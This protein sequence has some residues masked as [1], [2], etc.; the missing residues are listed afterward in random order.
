MELQQG[1]AD[2]IPVGG[3]FRIMCLVQDR[4][5]WMASSTLSGVMGNR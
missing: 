2:P 4:V 5:R 1:G 3:G